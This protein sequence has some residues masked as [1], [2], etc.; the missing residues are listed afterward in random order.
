MEGPSNRIGHLRRSHM[1]IRASWKKVLIF[2]TPAA[3][4]GWYRSPGLQFLN[5]SGPD[6]EHQSKQ[7]VSFS[8]YTEC[9]PSE[10][11][12][13]SIS[14]KEISMPAGGT[15]TTPGTGAQAW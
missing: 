14:S 12:V 7:L 4:H 15:R 10:G 1:G 3:P 13:L 8:L 5:S 9:A 11:S 6:K 2:S